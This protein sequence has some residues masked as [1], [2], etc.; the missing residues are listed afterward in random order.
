M[1][2]LAGAR[3]ITKDSTESINQ[4]GPKIPDNDTLYFQDCTL[5]ILGD[6]IV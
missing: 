1:P 5:Y 2:R 4:S 6:L 3:L